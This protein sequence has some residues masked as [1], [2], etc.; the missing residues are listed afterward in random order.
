[1]TSS[2]KTPDC[3]FCASGERHPEGSPCGM[4]NPLE[5]GRKYAECNRTACTMRPALWWNKYTQA[6]YCEECALRINRTAEKPICV[7]MV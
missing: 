5:K 4:A 2:P 6:F 1:M 3:S 7:R